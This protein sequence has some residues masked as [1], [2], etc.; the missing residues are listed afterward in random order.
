VAS[1]KS[2]LKRARQSEMRR[3]RNKAVKTR[4]KSA[5]KAVRQALEA[6]QK[7]EAA[8]ALAQAVPIIDKAAG[9]GVLHSRNASRKISRLSQQ[10]HR[11]HKA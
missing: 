11:L 1:H 4:V 9:K 6:G 8:K 10:V 3:L 5:V 2:A 7:D